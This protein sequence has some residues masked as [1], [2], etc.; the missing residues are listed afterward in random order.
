MQAL[1]ACL[2]EDKINV[3]TLRYHVQ[4]EREK[5]EGKENADSREGSVILIDDDESS[6][7]EFS[8]LTVESDGAT[9]TSSVSVSSK[10]AASSSTSTAS[11]C[12][13]SR[14][15]SKQASQKRLSDKIS[16]DEY[17][18]RY[19]V[20]FKE[21][22]VIVAE[23]GIQETVRAMIARLNHKHDLTGAKKLTKSTVYRQARSGLAG[24]SPKK[25]GPPSKIPTVFLECLATHTQVS[26]AGDGGVLC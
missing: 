25:M 17:E 5:Q 24:T 20:A 19:K 11:S 3:H 1:R 8:P 10:V 13:K 15:S 21:A 6:G 9:S 18:D 14:A 4:K 23:G 22:T 7:K 12:K 26:Q 16:K 2:L